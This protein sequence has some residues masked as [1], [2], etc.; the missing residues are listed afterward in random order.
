MIRLHRVRTAVLPAYC[1]PDRLAREQ[2]LIDM[3]LKEA[4]KSDP[5]YTFNEKFW[6]AA[7]EQL[8]QE[9][10]GKC[11]YCEAP[12]STVAYGDVE[13][14][15]PKSRY[16]WLA[17]CYDNYLYS[18]QICN[19]RHKRDKFPIGA[20]KWAGPDP[21]TAV[22]GALAIDPLVDDT[23]FQQFLQDSTIEQPLLPNP[24]YADPEL[25]FVW[26]ADD[27][28]REV[29][30][31]PNL[32]HA[33]ATQVYQAVQECLDLNRKE[34]RELRYQMYEWVSVVKLASRSPQID[35]LTATRC[36]A[37]LARATA[38]QAPFAG[39]ARYFAA[40]L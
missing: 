18:C 31:Q 12:T 17:Y 21:A 35:A 27:V 14:F 22:A 8:A 39:M 13:H 3:A 5:K 15:R 9:S 36:A 33:H 11:A 1:L 19:Q 26:Q 7:K 38:D 30:V 20:A 32:A 16:W 6:S 25:Y 10:H 2:E 23:T 40:T 34:L 28:V 24:Y 29:V 37:Q 4:G